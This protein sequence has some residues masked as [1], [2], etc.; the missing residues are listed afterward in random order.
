MSLNQGQ[1]EEVISTARQRGYFTLQ[2]KEDALDWIDCKCRDD[3]DCRIFRNDQDGP[4]DTWI[5]C[6][7]IELYLAVVRD[8]IEGVEKVLDKIN[9]R[10]FFV[11]LPEDEEVLP[12]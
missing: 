1:L 7:S 4:K 6:W 5:Y 9:E 12:L 11:P 2:D 3:N 8:N 10:R